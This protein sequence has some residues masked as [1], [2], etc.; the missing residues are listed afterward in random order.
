[1][2][3]SILLPFLIGAGIHVQACSCYGPPTFCGVLNPPYPEPEWWL[4]DAVVLAVPVDHYYYAADMLVVQAFAGPLQANDTVRVWGDNGGLCRLA[5]T[6]DLGDT[7]VLA[8]KATD[9][10][11]NTIWNPDFP[12]DLEQPGEYM[13]SI[14]G[15]YLLDYEAGQVL[16]PITEQVE[17]SMPLEEFMTA[18]QQCALSTGVAES[19]GG[20]GLLVRT[21]N[22]TPVLEWSGPTSGLLL[23]VYDGQGRVLL[24]REW[25]GTAF[26][27]AHLA[28]GSYVVEVRRAGERQ[29]RRLML[30]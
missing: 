1:M 9:F 26:T 24:R 29:A 11:G 27:L 4:P 10:M 6:W 15:V 22:G 5:A 17:Q 18:A 20:S 13:I 30:T 28:A 7:L 25:D 3:R 19:D 16:G 23:H 21:L 14:C 2:R 12:P 8:L